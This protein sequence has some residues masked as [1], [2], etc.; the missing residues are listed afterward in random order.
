MDRSKV[1]LAIDSERDYQKPFLPKV[2]NE[3][4]I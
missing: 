2:V 4:A 1:Y 3:Y